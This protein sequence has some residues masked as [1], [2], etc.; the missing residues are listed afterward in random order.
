MA[1]NSF[2]GDSSLGR[3]GEEHPPL[4]FTFSVDQTMTG[5][6]DNCV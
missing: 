4:S 3:S 1:C 6:V 2:D 5:S